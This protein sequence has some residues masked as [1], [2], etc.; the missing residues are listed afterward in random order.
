MGE[1]KT[2]RKRGIGL[3][4]RGLGA[5]TQTKVDGH[6]AQWNCRD[7]A[8]QEQEKNNILLGGG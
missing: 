4:P 6:P 1:N 5:K 3:I 8:W 2:L 7:A